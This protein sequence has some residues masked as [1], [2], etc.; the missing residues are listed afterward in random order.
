MEKE[1]R[2]LMNDQLLA[3]AAQLYG[4]S[5]QDLTYIGGFQNFVYEYDKGG[6]PFILRITHSSHRDMHAIHA[7]LDWVNDLVRYGISVSRPVP[8]DRGKFVEV[9]HLDDSEMFI[10]SF[11]KAPGN[12]IFYPECMN[13]DELSEKCGELTGQIHALSRN[14]APASTSRKRHHW[15]DNEYLKHAHRY[16]PDEQQQVLANLE[17]LKQQ[18]HRLNQRD[19]TYGLI[20]GDINVGNF[21][22]D[23]EIITLFDFDE[24]QYSWFVEDIAIQLFYMVYVVLD[25]S[26]EERHVQAR[27]FLEHFLKGYEKHCSI[28]PDELHH[29]EL[30]LRLRE[31]IVYVGMYRSFDLTNLNDWTETYLR[32]SRSRLEAGIPIVQHLF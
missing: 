14:Y 6:K 20:H 21:F 8:N 16:I 23:G 4:L 31:Y 10:A 13:N 18:I 5:Q 29:L 3:E 19:E 1:T 22:V 7:E 11:E 24:C 30:F 2:E 9:I 27:R 32:E 26:L 28:H 25:D 12:K 17:E 15:M